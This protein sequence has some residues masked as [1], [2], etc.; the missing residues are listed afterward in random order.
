M[1][2]TVRWRK[3]FNS[4]LFRRN[5][6][7][8]EATVHPHQDTN[9][10]ISKPKLTSPTDDKSKLSL[11]KQGIGKASWIMLMNANSTREWSQET[12]P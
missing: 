6:Q 7:A 2:R 11:H 4:E 12:P 10:F 5:L 8:K 1:A 3:A 9:A